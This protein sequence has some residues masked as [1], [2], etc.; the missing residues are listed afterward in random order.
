MNE[1]P[2]RIA[3]RKCPLV[4]FAKVMVCFRHLSKNC[5]SLLLCGCKNYEWDFETVCSDGFLKM[6]HIV[7]HCPLFI[8]FSQPTSCLRNGAHIHWCC[9]FSLWTITTVDRESLFRPTIVKIWHRNNKWHL[10]LRLQNFVYAEMNK[11]CYSGVPNSYMIR[12][13]IQNYG[14]SVNL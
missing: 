14:V 1:G 6:M 4:P 11:Q 12:E 13:R 7:G 2:Q 8:K 9:N 5:I 10:P 3:I